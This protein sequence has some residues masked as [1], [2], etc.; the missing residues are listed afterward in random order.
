MIVTTLKMTSDLNE[1]RKELSKTEIAAY[2]SKIRLVEAY[3][4]Q[5][6]AIGAEIDAL[7]KEANSASRN[8]AGSLMRTGNWAVSNKVMN[9]ASARQDQLNEYKEQV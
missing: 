6:A 8:I 1:K 5:T 3:G 2:E 9:A 7:N 4:R